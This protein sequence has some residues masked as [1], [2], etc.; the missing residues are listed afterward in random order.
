MSHLLHCVICLFDNEEL[1]FLLFLLAGHLRHLLGEIQYLIDQVKSDVTVF[2]VVDSSI[3]PLIYNTGSN[4][5]H[6]ALTVSNLLESCVPQRSGDTDSQLKTKKSIS[7][8]DSQVCFMLPFF[9][10]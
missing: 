10:L 6:S 7:L 8:E 9:K 3:Q 4:F 5:D 1:I 2:R